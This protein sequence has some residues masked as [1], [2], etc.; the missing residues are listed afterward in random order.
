M[1]VTLLFGKAVKD[2]LNWEANTNWKKAKQRGC[3]SI[4]SAQPLLNYHHYINLNYRMMNFL[5]F[6]IYILP[7]T[8]FSTCKP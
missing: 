8:G 3:A 2:I 7:A 1:I 4:T 6:W 5:P